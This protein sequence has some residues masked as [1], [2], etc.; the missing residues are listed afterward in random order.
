[1]HRKKLDGN[2]TRILRAILNKSW[3]QHSTKQQLYSH[4]PSI[5]KTVQVKRT[6]HVGHCWRSMEVPVLADMQNFTNNS[7]VRTQGVVWKTCWERWMI[8][9]NGERESERERERESWE[10]VVAIE[11]GTFG[12]PST[13][14]ANSTYVC[15]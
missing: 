8:G 4:L 7:S 14:V 15:K 10:C 9:T 2:C 3:K 11:K 1:M 12:L 5:S 13:K 6:R